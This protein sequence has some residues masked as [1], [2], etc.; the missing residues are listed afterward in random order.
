[1]SHE[2][3]RPADITAGADDDIGP[4]PAQNGGALAQAADQPERK[5]Q[6]G[7]D[8]AACKTAHRE[9]MEGKTQLRY[10]PGLNAPGRAYEMDLRLRFKFTQLFGDGDGRIEMAA[11]A[12]AGEEIARLMPLILRRMTHR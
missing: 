2:E 5:S 7:P 4:D 8:T 11:G 9:Q 3:H 12:A 10:D 1:M 6:I